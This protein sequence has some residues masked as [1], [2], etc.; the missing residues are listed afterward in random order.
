MIDFGAM[1]G[2]RYRT[3]VLLRP[4][5]TAALVFLHHGRT[6]R[7]RG[8]GEKQG[9]VVARAAIERER[10]WVLRNRVQDASLA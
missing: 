2:G 3:A 6:G 8:L 5:L 1:I 10:L 7:K 9:Q 4:N